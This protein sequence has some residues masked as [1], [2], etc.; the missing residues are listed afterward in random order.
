MRMLLS[1]VMRPSHGCA[2]WWSASRAPSPRDPASVR[3]CGRRA[4][5]RHPPGTPPARWRSDQESCDRARTAGAYAGGPGRSGGERGTEVVRELAFQIKR[6]VDGRRLDARVKA[7]IFA[8]GKPL[9]ASAPSAWDSKR[10]WPRAASRRA[11][12]ARSAVAGAARGGPDPGAFGCL[13]RVGHSSKSSPV[14]SLR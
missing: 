9:V 4:P 8:G 10:V 14:G 11:S 6:V 3:R 7:I 12:R 2:W 13:E 1:V 5:A